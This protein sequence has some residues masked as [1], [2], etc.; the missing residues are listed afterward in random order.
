MDN[1]QS[2]K[3]TLPCAESKFY[4]ELKYFTFKGSWYHHVKYNYL[5]S[6]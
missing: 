5:N 3:P 4:F 1:A 2:L 6:L